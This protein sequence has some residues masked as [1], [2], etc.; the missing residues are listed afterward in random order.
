MPAEGFTGPQ[1]AAILIVT[2]G[3]EASA[4]VFKNLRDEEIEQLTL[5]IARLPRVEAEERKA[6]LTEF[7]EMMMAQEFITQGGIEY[8][9][10]VLERALGSGKAAD[11][12]NRLISSLEVKPFDF[13]RKAEPGQLLHF[14]QNEHPQTIA[15]ILSYLP[16]EKASEVLSQLPEEIQTDVTR[17]I[18]FMDRTSPEVLREIER[19]L[20]KK[21]STFM[22]EEYA[23]I[24]GVDSVVNILNMSDRATE[25]AILEGLG[26]NDPELVEEIRRKM[27]VFED[28]V[29]LDDRSCQKVLREVDIPDLAL[30][31][32]GVEERIKE[33]VFSNLPKRTA[34]MLKDELEYLG[35]VRARDV[36]EAQQK[37]VNI[38][39]QL[40]E[41][42]DI[43]VS[44][45][46]RGEAIIE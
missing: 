41:S 23:A 40:E 31:L 27:F 30:A 13:I 38:I 1:K 17:R 4:Q 46:G 28:I 37:V 26:E 5:E 32:K 45:G 9:R 39:R 15:L 24:G 19:V 43:I 3:E 6:V 25:K 2:L 36:E 12:I 20:E 21:L 7:H 42:G 14:I 11:V 10:E 18:A 44:R 29:L 35:P 16:P 22:G 8:A 33:K 34:A